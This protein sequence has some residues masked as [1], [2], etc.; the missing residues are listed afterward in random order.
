[1]ARIRLCGLW[2]NEDSKGNK[3]LGGSLSG[4]RLAII[5]NGFKE[6]DNEPDYI[7]YIEDVPK[8]TNEAEDLI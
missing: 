2:V 5:K 8:R 1:M 7:V 6:K 4:A 3:Y